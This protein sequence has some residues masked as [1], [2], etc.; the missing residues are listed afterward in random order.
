MEQ[1]SSG[2]FFSTTSFRNILRTLAIVSFLLSPAFADVI[3][4]GITGSASASGTV[5][6]P[7]MSG[8]P[9]CSSPVGYVSNSFSFSGTNQS[10]QAS[11]TGSFGQT[12]T[13]NALVQQTTAVTPNSFAADLLSQFTNSPVAGGG[14]AVDESLSEYFAIGFNL[15]T[16]SSLR[17]TGA[18]TADGS[19]QVFFVFADLT[20]PGTPGPSLRPGLGRSTR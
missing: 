11:V 7:C 6:L 20:G 17:L 8:D 5:I 12:L 16:E 14:W 3:D 10:G 2:A 9:S 15:T 19:G 1:T 18:L 4:V 13:E